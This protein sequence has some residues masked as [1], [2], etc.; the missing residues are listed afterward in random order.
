MSQNSDDELYLMANLPP[1][2]TGLPMVVW[3][4]ERGHARHDVRIKV[5][6]SHGSQMS[7]TNT[8]TVAAR[9]V[10]RLVSGQLS[11]ADMAAVNAWI[12]LN[13]AAIVAYWD[14]AIYTDELLQRLQRL[15]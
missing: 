3:V 12:R 10:P 5:S 13:E 7:I 8:A 1:R 2:L 4:S 15:P 11:P 9:P 14:G 6:R